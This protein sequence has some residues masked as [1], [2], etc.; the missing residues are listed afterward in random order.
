ML[1]RLSAGL[2]LLNSS[3]VDISESGLL[4]HEIKET[5]L[6]CSTCSTCS[7]FL[8]PLGRSMEIILRCPGWRGYASVLC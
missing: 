7:P 4:A 8:F 2:C 6:I 3:A 5:G 1:G